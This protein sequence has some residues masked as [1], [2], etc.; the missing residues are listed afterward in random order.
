MEGLQELTAVSQSPHGSELEIVTNFAELGGFEPK[1]HSEKSGGL[2]KK[3][4]LG[5][6]IKRPEHYEANWL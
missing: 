2:V 1:F 5:N 4:T 3:G 6:S